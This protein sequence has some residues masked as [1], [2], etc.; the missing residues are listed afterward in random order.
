MADEKLPGDLN[1]Y[2]FES[3]AFEV[4][5]PSA[6][7][8]WDRAGTL[9][10]AARR[11]W[12]SLVVVSAEPSK[13]VFRIQGRNQ[14]TAG[15]ETAVLAQYWP[16]AKLDSFRGI[17]KQFLLLVTEKLEINTYNRIGFRTIF[18]HEMKDRETASRAFFRSKLMTVPASQ[19]GTK[20][21]PLMPEYAVRWE[22]DTLGTTVRIKVEGRELEFEPA[23]QFKDLPPIKKS[24]VGVAIDL[25]YYSVL[26]VPRGKVDADEWIS[27]GFRV[28][29]RDIQPYLE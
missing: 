23:P 19:F 22:G 29:K 26:P 14:L 10:E 15:V 8:H 5:Y 12:P 20:G 3:A 18:F 9:W 2:A 16:D 6:F 17:A 1:Q 11:L 24:T 4:R 21:Q 28:M 13:T 25:D 27:T 7:L